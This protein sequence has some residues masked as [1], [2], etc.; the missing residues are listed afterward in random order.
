M[1]EEAAAELIT[2]SLAPVS[3]VER[4]EEVTVDEKTIWKIEMK[5]PKEDPSGAFHDR[6]PRTLYE[7]LSM[8]GNPPL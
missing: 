8:T 2:G 1:D 6:K 4:N 5:F 3:V 7:R